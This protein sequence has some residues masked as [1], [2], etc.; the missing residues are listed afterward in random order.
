MTSTSGP[1]IRKKYFSEA[2]SYLDEF[3]REPARQPVELSDP[4]V[5][6]LLAQHRDDVVPP[7]HPHQSHISACILYSVYNTHPLT[8]SEVRRN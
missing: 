6:V 4:T 7:V 3:C 1:K 5:F 8:L 2:V